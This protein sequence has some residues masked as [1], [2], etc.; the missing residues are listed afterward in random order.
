MFAFFEESF[1]LNM[2]YFPIKKMLY[3]LHYSTGT[4]TI[5]KV[6]KAITTMINKLM[7]VIA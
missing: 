6:K 4:I 7:Y 1:C 2:S 3:R 5:I